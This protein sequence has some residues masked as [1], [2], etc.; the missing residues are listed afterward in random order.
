VWICIALVTILTRVT[1]FG[2]SFRRYARWAGDK[3]PTWTRFRPAKAPWS[4]SG[5]WSFSFT[6][7]NV[8]LFGACAIASAVMWI[9]SDVTGEWVFWLVLKIIWASWWVLQIT[10]VLV[11]ISV[12]GIQRQKALQQQNNPPPCPS[13]AVQQASE[14]ES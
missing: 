2:W 7:A 13:M 3:M 12:F 10:L 9:L 5:A 14:T 4:K 1:I 8:A 6:V 11:R